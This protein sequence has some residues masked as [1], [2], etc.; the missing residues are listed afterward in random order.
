M[1]PVVSLRK[2][3][4]ELSRAFSLRGWSLATSGNYSVRLSDQQILITASSLD[5]SV[6]AE[7]DCVIIDPSGV[8]QDREK[9]PSAESVLHCTLYRQ[10]PWVNA[11]LHTHSVFSTV[12][13]MMNRHEIVLEGYEMLKALRSV[14]SHEHRETLPIFPNSQHMRVLSTTAETYLGEHP[15]AH[16]FLIEGHGLYTWGTDLAEAKRHVEALEFLLECEYRKR[17]LH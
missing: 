13:S 6:L 11:I 4:A 3:I 10:L 7:T 5:K 9:R 17:V 14:T 2:E 16:G 8:R 15:G 1:K 12:L